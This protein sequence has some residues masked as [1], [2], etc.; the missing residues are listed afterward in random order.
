VRRS[1]SARRRRRWDGL[2]GLSERLA[3][4]G[5]SIGAAIESINGA[6]F[7]HER[8]ELAGWQVE[9]ADAQKLKGLAPLDRESGDSRA[10]RC[11]LARPPSL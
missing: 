6:R 1:L 2:G 8:L 9:I 7:V 11:Q 3:R 4:Q 10:R 5:A